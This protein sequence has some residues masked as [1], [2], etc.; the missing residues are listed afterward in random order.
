MLATPAGT[1]SGSATLKNANGTV[2]HT[3]PLN[4][5]DISA[6]GYPAVYFNPQNSAW[7]ITTPGTYTMEVTLNVNGT[8]VT[9][10]TTL[11]ITVNDLGQNPVNPST[12]LPPASSV[13]TDLVKVVKDPVTGLYSNVLPDV[14][15]NYI[16]YFYENGIPYLNPD[17]SRRNYLNVPIRAGLVKEVS[18][19]FLDLARYPTFAKWLSEGWKTMIRQEQI[20]ING[21]WVNSTA[22]L[23]AANPTAPT[24]VIYPNESWLLGYGQHNFVTA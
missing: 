16:G 4:N 12:G 17:G 15:G 3:E 2:L 23:E 18:V 11:T 10:S 1:Y 20:Q 7:G 9:A 5:L 22:E 13:R 24:R 19:V 6:N 21:S 14:I 8:N